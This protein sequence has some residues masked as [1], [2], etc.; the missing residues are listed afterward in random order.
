[1]SVQHDVHFH[2][3]RHSAPGP[4]LRESVLAGFAAEPK[5]ASPKFFY[6]RRGSELFEQICRQP[7]Y[8]LTSTE[9]AILTRAAADIAEIA[10]HH[11]NLVELGSGASRKVRLLLEAMH[12]ASYLGID[13]SRDFLL[14]STARLADDYPWLDV[15]AACADFCQPLRLPDDFDSEHPLAFFPGSS[16]G[17]FTPAEA[18]TLLANLHE[19]LPPGGGL[20]IGIDLVKDRQ[21]LEAA[22]NDAAGVTAA[23][24][25]NLL[26][27]IRHELD[28]DIE[29]ERFVHRA[30]FNEHESRIEMHLVSP[31]AQRVRIEDRRFAFAAGESLHTENS[32]KYSAEGF[33]ELAGRAGF[34]PLAS[35]SDPRGLFSVQYLERE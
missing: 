17:N 23:F 16:I 7:E 29:P 27:R 33:R 18:V 2:D 1:M 22:Y 32:Y 15:H 19:W 35:W 28:S 3:L 25:L 20:L 26:E 13:I 6:D 12:P 21:V 8:Y 14:D 4:G 5:W 30:F 11:A 10:G 24:N 9:E 31:Q 34:R